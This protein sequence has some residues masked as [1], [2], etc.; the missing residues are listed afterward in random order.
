MI[1][2]GQ[3]TTSPREAHPSKDTCIRA[4]QVL[5]ADWQ[6][7]SSTR[8]FLRQLVR[9]H[10]KKYYFP[11][12]EISAYS[13]EM[14]SSFSN[15]F[16]LVRPPPQANHPAKFPAPAFHVIG[17]H[18]KLF[19]SIPAK[20]PDISAALNLTALLPRGAGRGRG[21]IELAGILARTYLPSS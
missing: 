14:I 11:S 3:F 9:S 1:Y 15:Y 13:H 4:T 17:F 20:P 21:H 2:A 5:A 16:Y 6:L 8:P 10:N 7:T 19:I 18:W 12:I